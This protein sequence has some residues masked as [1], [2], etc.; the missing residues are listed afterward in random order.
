VVQSFD[1]FMVDL[2]LMTY[3]LFGRA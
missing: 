2:Y 3:C 1:Y